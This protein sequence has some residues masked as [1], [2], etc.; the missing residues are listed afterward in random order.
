MWSSV[1]SG[2]HDNPYNSRTDVHRAPSSAR[3]ERDNRWVCVKE[4]VVPLWESWSEQRD[5]SVMSDGCDY[6]LDTETSAVHTMTKTS[7][8]QTFL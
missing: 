5:G 4:T 3:A 6:I 7:P 1:S 8:E 2:S